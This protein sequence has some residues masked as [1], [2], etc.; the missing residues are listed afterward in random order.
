MVLF[1]SLVFCDSLLDAEDILTLRKVPTVH[2]ILVSLLWTH[3]PQH[4]QGRSVFVVFARSHRV[5]FLCK[6]SRNLYSQALQLCEG[7]GLADR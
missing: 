7:P 3:Y 2:I 4:G 5:H 6:L 1:Y